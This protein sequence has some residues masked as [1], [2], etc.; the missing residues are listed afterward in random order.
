MQISTKMVK[1]IQIKN[2][3]CKILQV[4]N[5]LLCIGALINGKKIVEN[6]WFSMFSVSE[7]ID[8]YMPVKN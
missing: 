2:R 6:Y 8:L 1:Q 3:L 7:S 5:R 4:V